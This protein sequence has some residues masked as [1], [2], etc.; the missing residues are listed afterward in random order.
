MIAKVWRGK[1]TGQWLDVPTQTSPGRTDDDG[2]T[3]R[4][5]SGSVAEAHFQV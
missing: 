2:I 3:D 4:K 1:K 5:K